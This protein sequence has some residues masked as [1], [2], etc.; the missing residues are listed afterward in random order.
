MVLIMLKRLFNLFFLSVSLVGCR[1]ENPNVIYMPDMVYSPAIKAQKGEM[2]N[3]VPGTIPRDFQPL[4]NPEDLDVA[5]KKLINPLKSTR[6]VLKRG[7][8]VFETNCAV[9]HGDKGNG[10]GYIIPKFPRPPSLHSEKVTQ[11]PDGR[12]YYVISKG[13]NLMPSYAAQVPPADRWAAIHYIRVLQRS[14][15]P[16]EA[17]LKF[18]DQESK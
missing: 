13:Q 11:W 7:Q 14:E 17:D 8:H 6:E 5:G 1:H 3:P 4:D 12:I 15:K 9:C 10:D 2:R 18:V 16:T